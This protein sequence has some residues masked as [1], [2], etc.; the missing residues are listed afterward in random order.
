[1]KFS[2][3]LG[4][5]AVFTMLMLASQATYGADIKPQKDAAKVSGAM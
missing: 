1:M 3:M 2:R 4:Y 5:V